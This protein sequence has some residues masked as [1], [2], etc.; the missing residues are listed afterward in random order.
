MR[1]YGPD[2][3]LFIEAEDRDML[4]CIVLVMTKD[5][6][7]F[8]LYLAIHNYNILV[9]SIVWLYQPKKKY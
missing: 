3:D 4:K 7:C 8:F 9:R 6:C 1:L 5:L 2:K